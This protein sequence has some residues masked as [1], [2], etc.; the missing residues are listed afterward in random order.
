MNSNIPIKLII[1][2]DHE[3]VRNG[4][5]KLLNETS[6]VRV[7]ADVG[8][9]NLAIQSTRDLKPH[10]LLL[11]IRLPDLSG[12]E[13][14]KRLRSEHIPT[15]ILILT[16]TADRDVFKKAI[17]SGADGYLLKDVNFSGLL[18]GI[19]EVAAGRSIIDPATTRQLFDD[20]QNDQPN[21]LS[22][23]TPQE[24]NI[25]AKVAEGKSNRDIA[26]D[27]E[28]SEKTVKNHL[29]NILAKLELKSRSQA[30]VFF[31]KQNFEN[32]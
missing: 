14:C 10:V 9:G 19:K 6:E 18:Q 2:E 20:I 8:T 32:S 24:K 4:L 15:K 12:I 23:L 13:V 25:L 7:V 28:L 5:V 30:A 22:L 11:D 21:K 31:L 17:A 16:S 29:T 1:A 26:L 3:V 27:F